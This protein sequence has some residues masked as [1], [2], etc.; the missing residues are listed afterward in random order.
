M[1][2]PLQ[3]NPDLPPGKL[4]QHYG[5]SLKAFGHPGAGGCLAFADP[6]NQISFAYTMNQMETGALPG[7]KCVGMIERLYG[8][9]A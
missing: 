3:T 2:D 4:R 8:G 9:A 7:P 6:E 1:K 5:P